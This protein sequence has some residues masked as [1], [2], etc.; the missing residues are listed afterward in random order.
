MNSTNYFN[1]LRTEPA[2]SQP[3][4]ST[5]ST[6]AS[7]TATVPISQFETT[8][9]LPTQSIEISVCDSTSTKTTCNRYVL[10]LSFWE[11]LTMA[12]TSLCGLTVFSRAWNAKTVSPFTR[13]AEFWGLPST[14]NYP[15]FH[16]M[17]PI[18][19]AG[20]T[21]SLDALFNMSLFNDKLLYSEYNIP[22]LA[23]F[24]NFLSQ[25]D[26]RITLI[27]FNFNSYGYEKPNRTFFRKKDHINCLSIFG[28]F[29]KK[30]LSVLNAETT[31]RNLPPFS[32]TGACC[33]NHSRITT[34]EEMLEKCGLSQ[35]PNFT[36]VNTVWRGFSG[37]LTKKFRLIVPE[38]SL[39][40]LR[41]PTPAI[42]AY[43][44]NDAI[45]KSSLKYF[46]SFTDG[47]NDFLA[48]HIRTAKVAMLDFRSKKR[49]SAKCMS[50]MWN[51]ISNVQKKHKNLPVK[52]FV[53]YGPYGSHSFEI[54]L[55]KKI[56]KKPFLQKKIVPLH[57]DPS[58]FGG[59]ADQGYVALVE[60]NTIAMAKVLV[61]IGGG[62]YQDQILTRFKINHSN[63][64][65]GLA[66]KACWGREELEAQLITLK[67]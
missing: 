60:Q 25:A 34:P 53:D 2:L 56:S 52:Y 22:P 32:I 65:G 35:L 63:N 40:S 15:W 45:L 36:I 33:V 64:K 42:D 30:L 58:K 43:P 54:G 7:S 19:G 8:T 12:T 1:M 16:G 3:T 62:S 29:S 66:Y 31:K 10:S 28:E 47:G 38:Q 20:P 24:E 57:Y 9:L 51:L 67:K 17:P 21:K 55:G 37:I 13:K 11:Q 5:T 27:H 39:P 18:Y 61:L 50:I 6:T 48:I 14:A 59:W 41:H 44:L 26:R 49:Y 23:T 46:K 4:Q